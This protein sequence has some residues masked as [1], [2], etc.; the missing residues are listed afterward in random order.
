MFETIITKVLNKVLGDFIEN[1]RPE[2]LDI[3]LLNGN[4]NLADM[5]LKPD[6]FAALPLPFA[7]DFG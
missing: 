3:S 6:L 5:K 2:Q 4:I 7:L 1:I